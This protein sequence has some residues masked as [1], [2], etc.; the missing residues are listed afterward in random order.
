MI[1]DIRFER[2][3]MKLESME[4]GAKEGVAIFFGY[5]AV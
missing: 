1:F 5:L 3:G 2:N 4:I